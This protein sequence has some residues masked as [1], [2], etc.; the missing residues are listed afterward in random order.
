VTCKADCTLDLSQCTEPPS[1]GDNIKNGTE[2]CDASDFG[3]ETCKTLFGADATGNLSCGNDC[4]IVDT[5]CL[6]CG[7][8]IKNNTEKC[9]GTEFG[10]TTCITEGFTGGT[11]GCKADCTPNTAQCTM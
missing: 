6:Y 1:C 4:K 11:I 10:T 7:D 8:G 3:S 2:E 9:D 5:A